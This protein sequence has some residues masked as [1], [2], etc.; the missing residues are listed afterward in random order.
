[1]GGDD[2]GMWRDRR[3]GFGSAIGIAAMWGLIAGRWTPRGP[4]TTAQALA[5]MVVGLAVGGVAGFA[6]RSRWS[7]AIAPLAFASVFEIVRLGTDGPTVDGF[8]ASEYGFLAAGV[9]RGFHALVAVVP[10]VLGAAVGAGRARALASAVPNGGRVGRGTRRGVAVLTTVALVALAAGLARPARTAPIVGPGGDPLAGSVA[11]LARVD[12]NGHLLSMMVRGDR[13]SNPVLLFLAGGPGGSELGAMRHHL[14]ALEHDF[15]VVT[16]DQRG[17]GRSYSGLEPIS[18]LT[19]DGAV[20]DAIAVTDHLRDRFGQDRIYLVGQSWG[21]ILGVLAAQVRPDL[22]RAFIGTGQMVSPVETDRIIYRDTMAWARNTANT[23]VADTLTT[24]GPPPYSSILDYEP[25]L[26]HE[27]QVYP[28]DHSANAEGRGQMG[29]GIF[30][31]E[32]A[33]IDQ[34]HIF[35][36]FLDTF[37]VLYPQIQDVDFRRD[38]KRLEVPVYF[39]QGAHEAAG[40]AQPFAQWYDGLVAPTKHVEVLD[41]S[42]HRPLFEQPRRFA[43]FLTGTVLPETAGRR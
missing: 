43:D 6:T 26:A 10:M 37:P 2:H 34:V 7:A 13:T 1:M 9:G 35:S 17:T 28:Y 23:K 5:A 39:V 36:G 38:V 4:V 19:L 29:E 20:S 14:Q 3:V 33:L 31:E 21:T 18:T 32:Y 24:I 11:D 22:Y 15:V 42:G 25:A 40:R 41:T 30:V 12:V 27:S 8:H 16:W